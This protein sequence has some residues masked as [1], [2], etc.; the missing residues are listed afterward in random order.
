MKSRFLKKAV[1]PVAAALAVAACSQSGKWQVSGTV[2]GADGKLMLLER[3]YNGNWYTLDSLRLAADGTFKFSQEPTGY[4]DIYRLSIDGRSLYFPID[5][6]NEI[7]VSTSLPEFDSRYTIGGSL[8]AEMMQ[9]VNEK[10][11]AAV[12]RSGASG[13]SADETLK[14]ELSGMI[15]GD[16]S[17]IVSY[18]IIN[19]SVGANK[20]FNPAD[21]ADLRIIG[22][23]ANAFDNFRP[24]DP[25]TP[26]IKNL[27]LSYRRALAE[28]TD[29]VAVTELTYFDMALLD[30][31]GNE[32]KLSDMV[33]KGRPVVINFTSYAA[34]ASP[35]FNIE[36]AKAYNAGG[37]DIYQVSVD[38]D[39][40]LWRDT[41]K[42]LPWTTVLNSP[43]DGSRNLVNYNVGALPATFIL[44]KNGNLVERVTDVTKL[45]DTL[46]KYK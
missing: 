6:V 1:F 31:K 39:E 10:I 4:P 43:K 14:R 15:L 35:A 22:A 13:V 36:L 37:V 44:D 2:D 41:A 23:V 25:R 29:T 33:G 19:K 7:T 20:I 32:Q 26:Y 45:A 5:S 12:A 3:S 42:N 18:Y 21:K 46:K 16:Q 8:S 11:A 40:F 38:S 28:P 24:D 17:G 34:E 30:E 9:A 27:Y